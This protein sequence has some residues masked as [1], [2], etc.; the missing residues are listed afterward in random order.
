MRG[1]RSVGALAALVGLL[2]CGPK[3]GGLGGAC[4]LASCNASK[5]T[6]FCETVDDACDPEPGPVCVGVIASGGTCSRPCVRD[7]DCR[8]AVVPMVCSGD[9]LRSSKVCM[10]VE[11]ARTFCQRSFPA[12]SCIDLQL[13]GDGV[14]DGPSGTNLCADDKAD[15]GGVSPWAEVCYASCLRVRAAACPLDDLSGCETSCTQGVA[16]LPECRA[17]AKAFYECDMRDEAHACGD[18]QKSHPTGLCAAEI[19]ALANCQS[20]FR[21]I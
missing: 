16:G 3:N 1:L 13:R 6:A 15:C 11:D 5:P 21:G 4:S 10:R 7:D 18:D 9:C 17:Q 19:T 14:C 8:G 12:V 20:A 2:G